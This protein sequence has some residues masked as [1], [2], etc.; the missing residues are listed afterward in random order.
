MI[1]IKKN[2]VLHPRYI[3]KNFLSTLSDILKKKEVG[4]CTKESGYIYDISRIN[5]LDNTILPNGNILFLVSF[6]ASNIKPEIGDEITP[7]VSHIFN[8][9]VILN[10]EK[11]D[12]LIPG[13]DL[14]SEGWSYSS[15]PKFSKGK[16]EIN[17]GDKLKVKIT[18]VRYDNEK[19]SCIAKLI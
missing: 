6:E 18:Q 10:L 3:N 15:P 13:R 7:T 4:K 1:L 14:N 11:T 2:I 17:I 5:I 19:F 9:G 12:V 8:H 16:E